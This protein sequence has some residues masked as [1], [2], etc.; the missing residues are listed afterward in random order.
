MST[1]FVGNLAEEAKKRKERLKALREKATDSNDQLD[2]GNRPKESLPKPQFRSYKP[3]DENLS[4]TQKQVGEPVDIE[5]EVKDQ[6]ESA[7]FSN[8]VE[9]VDL[10]NLAPRKP[11]WDLKRDIS[12]KLEKLNRRTQRA[13]AEIIKE[14]LENQ[15]AAENLAAAVHNMKNEESND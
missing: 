7:N 14:R 13:I 12:K 4:F 11:D 10:I 3:Q 6:L 9:E 2:D 5:P 15:G 1:E 8:L